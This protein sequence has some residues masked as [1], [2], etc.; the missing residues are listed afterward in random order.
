MNNGTTSNP[1]PLK[2]ELPAGPYL[3]RARP[4]A[5]LA[6]EPA[7]AYV[8]KLR[9]IAEREGE[10]AHI[11]GGTRSL[12]RRLLAL[13]LRETPAVTARKQLPGKAVGR[14]R[15]GVRDSLSGTRTA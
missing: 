12:H 2:A 15:A 1:L 13:N 9:S 6:L 10:D 5:A 7:G 14:K 3:L 8:K 11:T 4:H